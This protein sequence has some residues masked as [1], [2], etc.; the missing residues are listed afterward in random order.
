[1]AKINQPPAEPRPAWPWPK[2]IRDR[3]VQK[4]QL[5]PA[6]TQRKAGDPKSPPL[7]SDKLLKSLSTEGG[8]MGTRLSPP[9]VPAAFVPEAAARAMRRSLMRRALH[10]A[11]KSKGAL[12]KL[13]SPTDLAR[14][15][16]ARRDQ[17]KRDLE[18]EEAMLKLL[19]G[20][21]S[22]LDDIARKQAGSGEGS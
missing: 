12:A 21:G 15:P 10:R 20:L 14:L 19:E 9:P 18:R 3:I 16:E 1:M 22:E 8:A 13:I 2:D 5:E 11:G 6:K 4:G 7:V 17:V